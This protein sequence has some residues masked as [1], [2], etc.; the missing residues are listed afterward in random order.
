LFIQEGCYWL[1]VAGYWLLVAGRLR[2]GFGGL[3]LLALLTEALA[4]VS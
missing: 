1:L 2:Q 4:K 3:E